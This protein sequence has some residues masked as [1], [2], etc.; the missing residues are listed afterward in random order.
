MRGSEFIY[1]NSNGEKYFLSIIIANLLSLF[2]YIIYKTKALIIRCI[3][4]KIIEF[5]IELR[6]L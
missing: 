5:I 2:H 4:P 6:C 3:L 1:I